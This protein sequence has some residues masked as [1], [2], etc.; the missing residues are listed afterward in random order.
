M[1]RRSV[2]VTESLA[3]Q[4]TASYPSD[5][6]ADGTPSEL[7]FWEGP[8]SRATEKFGRDFEGLPYVNDPRVR[9]FIY[10]DPVFGAIGFL[11]IHDLAS[12][13]IQLIEYWSDPDYW[14]LVNRGPE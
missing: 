1:H 14:D 10:P 13:E 5:R 7:D 11:G 4:V 9:S 3:A 8:I 12:D 2:I 6:A